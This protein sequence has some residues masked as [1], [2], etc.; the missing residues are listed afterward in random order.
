M[1]ARANLFNHP[2]H[3]ALIPFPFAFL[4]GSAAFDLL[5]FLTGTPAFLRTASHLAVAGIVTA[6]LAGA[7]GAV[8]YV[9]TVPPRSSAKRRARTHA[10]FNLAA[11]V[12]FAIIWAARGWTEP[13]TPASSGLQL[14]AIAALIYGSLQGGTLVIRNMVTVDHRH[15]QSGK[16]REITV[17]PRSGTVVVAKKDELKEGQMKLVRAGDRRLVLART[18]SGYVAF[19]D[20]CT[21]RGAS[22]A[23][24]VLVGGVV[25]CLWH[26]SRFDCASGQVAGGPAKQPVAT[27][28]VTEQRDEIAI[29]L[30][31]D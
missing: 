18:D 3:P 11:V 7:A 17:P 9:Y 20:R 31:G 1:R 10:I 27:Y 12:L 15:A 16:W 8:D 5:A 25:Q 21:H 2:I 4:I 24:G 14:I 23:D 28:K 30:P 26:G 19:D 22:L 29:T 6:L 13:P